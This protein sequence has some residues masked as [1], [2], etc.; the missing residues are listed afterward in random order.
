V[1]TF[2]AEWNWSDIDRATLG[3]L[4]RNNGD[5]AE[6]NSDGSSRFAQLYSTLVLDR[7]Q[8]GTLELTGLTTAVT[9][10]DQLVR[11]SWTPSTTASA[12]LA[13]G[14]RSGNRGWSSRSTRPAWL[15]S[16]WRTR[17]SN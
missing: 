8:H 13:P 6:R 3:R 5:W 2:Q 4:V 17:S 9:G 1:L 12:H 7:R 14:R 15:G 11:T 10:A 16:I